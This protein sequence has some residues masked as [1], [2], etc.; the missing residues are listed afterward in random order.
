MDPPVEFTH[1]QPS[2]PKIHREETG[3]DSGSGPSCVS[4]KSDRSMDKPIR[5][6]DVEHSDGPREPLKR[7]KAP[8]GQSAQQH[9]TDLDSI[10]MLLQ[11]NISRFVE[12][13]LKK[14]QRVLSSDYPQSSESQR[15]DEEQRSSREA[16]V[17]ITLHFLRSMKQEELAERL[18]SSK[19]I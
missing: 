17:N 12:D 3:P 18:Q 5:F 14:I 11:E 13:E 7:L 19:R 2:D 4:F 9:H 15:E 6:K 1:G 16:F 8:R 10:F